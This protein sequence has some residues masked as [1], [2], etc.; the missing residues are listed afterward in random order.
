M[1][2]NKRK[3]KEANLKIMVSFV[4]KFPK[5]VTSRYART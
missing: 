3:D 4:S 1:E 5:F 2:K